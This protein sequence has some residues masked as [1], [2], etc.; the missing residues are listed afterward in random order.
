MITVVLADDHPV[1]RAGMAQVL[2]ADDDIEIVAEASHGGEAIAAAREH[3]PDVVLMDLRMPEVDGVTAIS[4]LVRTD[5][6][7][8]VL[9]LTTYDTDDLIVGAVEAGAVGYLLKDTD[10]A[11][12]RDAVRRAARGETVLS[13]PVAARLV[14]QLRRPD[15][16]SLT[17]RELEILGLVAEGFTNAD[18]AA[19][20]HVGRATVKTHLAHVFDKLGVSDRTA[21]VATAFR[22]GI[23]SPPSRD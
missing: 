3:R 20:L 18:I 2:V 4:E 1:V 23:L 11:T 21:A 6:H 16:T 15:A 9:V 14:G 13:P 5:P 19:Q 8:R 7:I 12:L 22:Q 10:P 17:A